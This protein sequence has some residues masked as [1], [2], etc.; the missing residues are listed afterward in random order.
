VANG[1]ANDTALQ[2]GSEHR[3]CIAYATESLLL[4]VAFLVGKTLA[5]F[6]L[7]TEDLDQFA[8]GCTGDCEKV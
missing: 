3:E 2:H 8:I 4:C 1:T 5:C 7:G 6:L